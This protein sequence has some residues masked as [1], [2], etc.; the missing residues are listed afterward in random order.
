MVWCLCWRIYMFHVTMYV[1][2]HFLVVG[3]VNTS[4]DSG[5]THLLFGDGLTVVSI[6]SFESS[7]PGETIHVN[8]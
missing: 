6:I 2:V 4:G 8:G 5:V 7:T 3:L 1:H